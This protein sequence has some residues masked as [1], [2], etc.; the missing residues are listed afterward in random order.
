MRI[1]ITGAGGSGKSTLAN[2]LSQKYH[3]SVTHLDELQWLENWIENPQY[4]MLQDQAIQEE[5]WIIEGS[6]CSIIASMES[7]VDTIIILNTSPIGNVLRI[8]KR[9]I[10]SIWSKQIGRP[11]IRGADRLDFAFL[12]RTLNWK[13]RQLPRIKKIIDDYSLTSRVV[14]IGSLKEMESIEALLS[15]GKV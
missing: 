4:R 1:Y 2:Q 15:L 6:S 12:A 14:E 3:I 13:Q 10:L 7:R 5:N 11:D 9:C 8:L